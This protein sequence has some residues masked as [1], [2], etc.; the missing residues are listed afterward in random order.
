MKDNNQLQMIIS[1]PQKI[2]LSFAESILIRSFLILA[3]C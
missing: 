1:A 2:V 3:V